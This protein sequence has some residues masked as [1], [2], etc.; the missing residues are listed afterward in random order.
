MFVVL[1][2][3]YAVN[4]IEINEFLLYPTINI[5][6]IDHLQAWCIAQ[7]PTASHQ[8]S[9]KM[10]EKNRQVQK[11]MRHSYQQVVGNLTRDR[12]LRF[13]LLMLLDRQI[14]KLLI[15]NCAASLSANDFYDGK[16]IS[17]TT[18]HGARYSGKDVRTDLEGTEI[19][20]AHS[21]SNS[22]TH[23][24]QPPSRGTGSSSNDSSHHLHLLLLVGLSKCALT[25][26]RMTM[27][28]VRWCCATID[29][30]MM[31]EARLVAICLRGGDV[32]NYSKSVVNGELLLSVRASFFFLNCAQILE[33]SPSSGC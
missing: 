19:T 5:S 1:W 16:L 11:P 15:D 17:T 10:T 26:T 23:H 13:A 4:F 8:I 7:F 30:C 28:I 29:D 21:S 31:S 27:M 20:Q 24:P 2:N 9:I 18:H 3:K 33:R 12:D 14:L 25:V 22:A 32:P 6:T